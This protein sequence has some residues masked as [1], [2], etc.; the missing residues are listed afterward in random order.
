MTIQVQEPKVR[1]S[2]SEKRP[3]LAIVIPL[4]NMRSRYTK[5]EEFTSVLEHYSELADKHRNSL[6]FHLVDDG[7]TDQSQEL[8]RPFDLTN[9]NIHYLSKNAQKIGAIKHVLERLDPNIRFILHTDFDCKFKPGSLE[10]ALKDTDELDLNPNLGGFGLRVVPE[11]TNTV[12]G[13]F[14]DLEYGIGR[15]SYI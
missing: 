7:S 14:Q 10:T 5:T 8:L 11:D 13:A 4:Y 6:E 2:I 9:L 1:P 3:N 12:L 15:F